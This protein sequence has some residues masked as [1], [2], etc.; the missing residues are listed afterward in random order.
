MAVKDPT[1][2]CGMIC[3]YVF[4]FC[5]VTRQYKV[6]RF[7]ETRGMEGYNAELLTLGTHSWK[8]VG[9]ALDS[10]YQ[11]GPLGPFLYGSLHWYGGRS[12]RLWAFYFSTE[13]FL[14]LPTPDEFGDKPRFDRIE[15]KIVPDS[16]LCFCCISHDD[17]QSEV[18]VMKEYGVKDSWVKQFVIRKGPWALPFVALARMDDGKILLSHQSNLGLYDPETGAYK[19][20]EVDGIDICSVCAFDVDFSHMLGAKTQVAKNKGEAKTAEKMEAKI[21]ELKEAQ[22]ASMTTIDETR[23]TRKV[24]KKDG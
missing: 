4:G 5:A 11:A 7:L 8:R 19:R 15:C 1:S 14:P 16:C 6:L 12:N 10:Y 20:V 3:G 24:A 18:W 9:V 2:Q 21:R 13:R 23:L 17:L 22:I